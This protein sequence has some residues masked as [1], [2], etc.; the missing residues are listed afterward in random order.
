MH[1]LMYQYHLYPSYLKMQDFAGIRNAF[2]RGSLLRGF[3]LSVLVL[4]A[5]SLVLKNELKQCAPL[6]RSDYTAFIYSLTIYPNNLKMRVSGR[7]TDTVANYR[8]QDIFLNNHA[9]QSMCC[10][11]TFSIPT[12]SCISKPL[13]SKS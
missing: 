3:L 2:R 8:M 1:I 5:L 10:L 6:I 7:Y 4:S 11:K 13:G 9:I 12:E